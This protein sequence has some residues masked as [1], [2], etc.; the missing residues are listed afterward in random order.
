MRTIYAFHFSIEIRY[1]AVSFIHL[2]AE[3]GGE[4]N[5]EWF[6]YCI[7]Q[8]IDLLWLKAQEQQAQAS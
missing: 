2:E 3:A 6:F 4:E 8:A 7:S 5:R 1:F